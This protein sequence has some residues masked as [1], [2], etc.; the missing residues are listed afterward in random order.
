MDCL[1]NLPTTKDS[2]GISAAALQR[3]HLPPTKWVIPEVLP[4]GLTIL[5]GTPKAEKSWLALDLALSVSTG[6]PF[7][8]HMPRPDSVVYFALKDSYSRVQKRINLILSGRPAPAALRLIFSLERDRLIA[9]LRC[10]ISDFKPCLIVVDTIGRLGLATG[11][12]Y[13]RVYE[14]L[15]AFKQLADDAHIGIVTV[16]HTRK[17][18]ATDP[19]TQI[20]GSTALAGA[21]DTLWV[22]MRIRAPSENTHLYITG[23]DIEEQDLLL[24]F[25]G[26]RWELTDT[27]DHIES[28]PLFQFLFQLG[29][30]HGLSS[31]L[32]GEY[33]VY[34]AS[35]NLPNN[36]SS[37][38][39]IVSF[40]RQL[41]QMIPLL[42][43]QGRVI[44]I[45]HSKLG[46]MV[47]ISSGQEGS[48]DKSM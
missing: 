26:H 23:R 9:D 38:N 33:L 39:T 30:F 11:N 16:T 2:F 21:V 37:E 8:G 43:A 40:G 4:S 3:L 19:F 18:P 36:L 22:M 12:T 44:M 45:E 42:Q 15:S 7:L 29:S 25:E 27:S 31:S 13:D 47:S 34:C 32:C 35:R 24:R 10:V 46:N 20:L 17:Q 6:S 48:K 28:T 41:R 14:E 1:S 5:A